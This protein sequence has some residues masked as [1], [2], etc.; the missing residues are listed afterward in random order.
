MGKSAK[1]SLTVNSDMTLIEDIEGCLEFDLGSKG[2]PDDESYIVRVA[3]REA[4]INAVKWGG[5]EPGQTIDIEYEID[6]RNVNITI[7]DQ[8]NKTFNYREF[9]DNYSAR[10][11]DR[12]D[13]IS[14]SILSGHSHRIGLFLMGTIMDTLD[15]TDIMNDGRKVGTRVHMVYRK[16]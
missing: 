5:T 10:S 4:L 8:G 1:I 9:L 15:V 7:T 11:G 3:A 16:K 12:A 13:Y 6:E 2:Y 14:E